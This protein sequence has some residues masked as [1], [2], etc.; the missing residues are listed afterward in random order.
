MDAF[1]FLVSF[2]NIGTSD[3]RF[4]LGQF[5]CDDDGIREIGYIDLGGIIHDGAFF[6]GVTGLCLSG[7][8]LYA[9]LQGRPSGLLIL[10]PQQAPRLVRLR[11]VT[12]IHSLAALPDG[13]LLIVSTGSDSLVT[14][15]PRTDTEVLHTRLAE[16]EQ[17]SLHVNGLALHEGR[18]I[19]SML[20]TQADGWMR[21]GEVRDLTRGTTLMTGLRAPHSVLSHDGMV[22]VLESRTGLLLCGD[23]AGMGETTEQFVGYARG[24]QMTQG[25]TLVGR[26]AFRIHSASFGRKRRY[27]LGL[28]REG[29]E[30]AI[31]CLYMQGAGDRSFAL[32]LTDHA[33]EIYD[34]LALEPEAAAALDLPLIPAPLVRLRKAIRRR[35]LA[36]AEAEL[37]LLEA[38]EMPLALAAV[39]ELR[40]N[41]PAAIEAVKASITSAADAT[42]HTRLAHLYKQARRREDALA[43]ARRAAEI[44]PEAA[45]LH[46]AHARLAQVSGLDAEAL[47]ALR[48]AM[49]LAPKGHGIM[50]RMA[51]LLAATDAKDEA[52][53][54]AFR[55]LESENSLANRI[56]AA[57]ILLDC[58]RVAE[59]RALISAERA[60]PRYR[61]AILHLHSRIAL[62]EGEPQAALEAARRAVAAEPAEARYRAHLVSLLLEAGREEEAEASI[63]FLEARSDKGEA[64]MGRRLRAAARM[65]RSRSP[66]GG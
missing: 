19:V 28:D 51:E 55:A 17:N 1:Q 24:L 47:D 52:A 65:R 3:S 46:L 7:G 41:F 21:S 39:E 23:P 54:W 44:R 57:E 50:L 40:G 15:D 33:P 27:P 26:S 6:G 18:I 42:P 66:G 49:A 2:C 20:G 34:I 43:S 61:A 63:A 5:I 12:R 4:S 11:L 14:F 45:E 9:G 25:V 29:P 62:L 30:A 38:A 31:C 53:A 58:G 22:Y 37:P 56:E 10:T 13:R 48:R 36:G 60:T 8:I 32:D 59:A 35:D 16:G 64:K